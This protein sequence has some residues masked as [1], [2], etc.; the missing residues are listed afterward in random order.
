MATAKRYSRRHGLA[1]LELVMAIPLL[2]FALALSVIMG[3]VACWKV[4]ANVVARDAIFARRWPR[5][6][7]HDQLYFEWRLEPDP[8]PPEWRVS[9]SD[10]DVLD[11]RL[12]TE[13]DHPAF[14]NP[15]IRGPLM[16]IPADSKMLDQKNHQRVGNAKLTRS[17]AALG[18]LGKYSLNVQAPLLDGKWQFWQLGL[19][20]NNARRI[21]RLYGLAN[22]PIEPHWQ[23][24]YNEARQEA[25]AAYADPRGFV[26]D[27]DEEF[28]DWYGFSPDFHPRLRPLN[29]R[30]PPPLPPPLYPFCST[31]SDFVYQEHV[32]RLLPRIDSVPRPLQ[33]G[34]D[35]PGVAE[36]M[37]RAFIRMYEAQ[38]DRLQKTPVLDPT[39]MP[40]MQDL[41]AKIETLKL[42]LATLN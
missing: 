13:L 7:P 31:D 1:P 38:L 10:R 39:Q 26:L 40:K 8:D 29:Q 22:M 11:G 21:R 27:R 9:S 20:S 28:R 16:G 14:Q 41:Q 15:I 2:I 3:A 34:F 4:R 19:A 36:V 37:T 5:D 33:P 24:R 18:K 23:A 17:P 35:P 32:G 6:E 12:I 25:A 42:F 30:P